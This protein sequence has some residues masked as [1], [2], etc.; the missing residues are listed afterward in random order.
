MSDFEYKP[1]PEIYQIEATNAC[2]LGCE[3]CPRVEAADERGGLVHLDPNTLRTWVSRGDLDGS[4]FVELQASGEPLLNPR[5]GEV[6]SVLKEAGVMVGMS[7][8]GLLLSQKLEDIKELDTLTISLDTMIPELYAKMRPKIT[9][10]PGDFEELCSN[11]DV[12]LAS[13]H[14]PPFVDLQLLSI[15]GTHRNVEKEKEQVAARWDHPSL[16]IRHIEDTFAL[17]QKR[18]KF[19]PGSKLCVNPWLSVSVLSNGDVS[20]CCY[21]WGQDTEN[22]YGNLNDQPLKDIWNGSRVQALRDSL[23]SGKSKGQCIDCYFRSPYKIHLGFMPT[24]T[25]RMSQRKSLRVI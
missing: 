9:G 13:E 15:M 10:E 7:T 5:I 14:C 20:S 21:A 8:N 2:Q 22:I 11:I 1:L 17:M 19:D 6:I 16:K 18:A 4:Y 24:I 25:R 23:T 3:T 12:L